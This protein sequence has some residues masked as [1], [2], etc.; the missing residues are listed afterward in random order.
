MPQEDPFAASNPDWDYALARLAARADPARVEKELVGRGLAPDEARE[1][2]RAAGD[3]VASTRR[4]QGVM[5]AIGGAVLIVAGAAVTVMTYSRAASNPEGGQYTVW[6]G[7][8]VFGAILLF[9]GMTL[10][11]RARTETFRKPSD[12]R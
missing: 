1:F 2:I 12:R 7:A 9:R 6:Y 10:V 8:I 3:Q 4:R 11:R 5:Q